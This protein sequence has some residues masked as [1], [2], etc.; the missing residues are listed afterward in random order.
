MS[1]GGVGSGGASAS[2]EL[3]GDTDCAEVAYVV[4]LKR[5]GGC[6]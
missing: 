3:R 6:T 4:T 1:L 2:T 5:E